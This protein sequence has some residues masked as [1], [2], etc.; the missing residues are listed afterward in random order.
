MS[1]VGVI[2]IQ[3]NR[4]LRDEQIKFDQLL[5]EEASKK[6]KLEEEHRTELARFFEVCEFETEIQASECNDEDEI[7]KLIEENNKLADEI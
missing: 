7:A 1:Y 5:E 2:E 3:L 4:Q 6:E